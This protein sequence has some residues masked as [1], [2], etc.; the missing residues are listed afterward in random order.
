MFWVKIYFQLS[1]I[2]P[3][4]HPSGYV[5]FLSTSNR[6]NLF[7]DLQPESPFCHP[8]PLFH[9]LGM[10]VSESTC[11]PS[12]HMCAP[13]EWSSPI[14][15]DNLQV[16]APQNMGLRTKHKTQGHLVF[17]IWVVLLIKSCEYC[18]YLNEHKVAL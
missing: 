18:K 4:P 16:N 11:A 2:T 15:S 5:S 9:D 17:R 10:G 6:T 3:Y 12:T 13:Q 1:L 14:L 8:S 7:L